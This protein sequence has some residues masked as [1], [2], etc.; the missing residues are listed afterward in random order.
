MPPIREY[1]EYVTK[2]KDLTLEPKEEMKARCNMY[3]DY[4]T[5]VQSSELGLS[6]KM[7]IKLVL[8]FLWHVS[9][10]FAS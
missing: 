2:Y 5:N 3:I 10:L 7:L 6:I 4:S 8:I 1:L 9:N